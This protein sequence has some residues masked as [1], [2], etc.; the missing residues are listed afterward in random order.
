[1]AILQV[2][3]NNL[4]TNEK[5][6]FKSLTTIGSDPQADINLTTLGTPSVAAHIS[7]QGQT[8][9]LIATEPKF[10]IRVNNQAVSK[11]LL[12]NKDEISIG[13]NKF[14]F[15][16]SQQSVNATKNPVD[17]NSHEIIAY[18]KLLTFSQEIAKEKQI[19]KI[20]DT[21]IDEIISI[22]KAEKGFLILHQ[23]ETTTIQVARNIQ[24]HMVNKSGDELSDS[25]LQKVLKTK[26]PLVVSDALHDQEFS[27]STSV[28]NYKLTSIMCA[29][30]LYKDNIFGAI[31][32]GNNSFTAAF[33]KNSLE[34]LTIF[35]AQAAMLVQHA[36]K[37]NE[38]TEQTQSLKAS[39]EFNKFGGIIGSC[40]TMQKVFGEIDKIANSD[41]SALI[42]GEP[43]TGK[44]LIAREI[45]RRSPRQAGPFVVF[46]C[47]S[48]PDHIIESELFGHVRGAFPQ[49]LTSRIGRLQIADHGT[50]FLEDIDK[51][52]LAIQI[53]IARALNEHRITR[54]GDNKSEEINV[55]VLA[56]TNKNL[57][58]MVQKESFRE[59]LYY[60]L[61]TVQINIPAL[62]DRGND[63]LVIANYFLQKYAKLYGKNHLG[64]NEK[65][66]NAIINYS[67]PG[68]VRQLENRIKRAVVMNV[69]SQ[70]KPSDLEIESSANLQIISLNEAIEKFRQQYI[71]EALE[72]N[73]GNRTQTAKELGVDPR[74]IFRH[75][76]DKKRENQINA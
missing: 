19:N 13:Q 25:I 37:I 17:S 23:N 45:H 69:N 5:I 71:E 66:Q 14:I 55:R 60:L 53:K 40:D 39:L 31:Y 76:E 46:S 49:A 29:P 32:V 33:D 65:T 1:M 24:G 3:T 63:I 44:E 68:N 56:T 10:A 16:D 21:L 48:M 11:H 20:L 73:A 38:L 28:I 7:H 30:L 58:K 41:I 8:F 59:D 26:I 2:Y 72:R 36:L 47:V 62:K 64:L 18:Q 52:P 70:I 75:L 35:A 54:M 57:M 34:I 61:S 43:G 12:K 4:L 22:T 51:I 50:L 67:W 27:S 42:N 15:F 6:L 9:T 74:T